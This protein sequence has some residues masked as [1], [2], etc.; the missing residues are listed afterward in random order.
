MLCCSCP[1]FFRR[2]LFIKD[3]GTWEN[4]AVDKGP[5]G[6]WLWRSKLSVWLAWERPPL[7]VHLLVYEDWPERISD[8]KL[9]ADCWRMSDEGTPLQDTPLVLASSFSS[10][11]PGSNEVSSFPPPYPICC[12]LPRRS[13][14]PQAHNHGVSWPRTETTKTVSQIFA[15]SNCFKYSSQKQ[16]GSEHNVW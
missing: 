11:L 8:F 3:R 6:L 16:N 14:S 15:L 10:L 4:S 2:V 13:T 9:G 1:V 7:A 12:V 5:E